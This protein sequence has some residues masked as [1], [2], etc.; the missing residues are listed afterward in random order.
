MNK[1]TLLIIGIIIIV[2]ILI[3]VFSFQE[4]E[5][6]PI[7][8]GF[9]TPLS[10]NYAYIGEDVLKGVT[11]AIDEANEKGV[12]DR[13]I[14]L[15][16]ED[17]QADAK[18]AVTNYKLLKTKGVNIIFSSFSSITE[19]LTPLVEQ[20]KTIL[21]YNAIPTD[22]AEKN[23]YIFKVYSNATQEAEVISGEIN[24][25]SGE[26]AWVYV[27][28]PT[29]I[30]MDDI[31]SKEFEDLKKYKFEINESDFRTI[32]LKLKENNIENIILNGYPKQI[33]DFVKQ[34][35]ESNYNLKKLFVVSDGGSK[36]VVDNIE[37]YIG[38]SGLK[39]ILVGYGSKSK[40]IYYIFSYD[41][42]KVLI[43]GME[44]CQLMNK[45]PDNPECLK[46]ELTK[47]NIIGKSGNVKMTSSGIAE[48]SPSLYTVKNKELIIYYDE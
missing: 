40:E 2:V 4:K 13:R 15:L 37:S 43:A 8:I 31:F 39:Y 16:V 46:E 11:E 28:N 47:V 45:E 41:L 32:I 26:K 38:D 29:S 18:T 22:F 24:K 10:G 36:D 23:E 12:F 14:E 1:K 3:I 33:I 25:I 6:E 5:K 19:A 34:S 21:M 48:L 20:E 35:I 7:K 30:V 42:A 44:S 27:N 9:T 17:N